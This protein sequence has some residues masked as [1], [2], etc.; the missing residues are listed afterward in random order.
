MEITQQKQQISKLIEDRLAELEFPREPSLLYDPVRYTLS[1]PGKRVRPYLTLIGCGLCGGG[2]IIKEA[3]PAAVSMELLHNFTL[4]HD[5]IMDGAETRRGAPSVYKKWNANTAILSG[6]AMYAKA[7]RRL[8]YYGKT[9]AFSK[10][11][12]AVILDLFLD[13]A[14]KVCEGQASDLAFETTTDVTIEQYLQM[15][16]GK[17]AALISGS[18]A[19]GGA[20]AGAGKDQLKELKITGTKAGIAFQIQDDL[21]DATAD[22]KKFGKKRGGDIIEG[23]KTYLT[24]LTLQRGNEQQKE[25]LLKAL[26]KDAV[27]EKEIVKV[28]N[29]Y[30]ELDILDDTQDAI[31]YYY[32]SAVEHLKNFEPSPFKEEII[33]FFN[34]LISREF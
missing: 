33:E 9:E 22:P 16:D 3:L 30:D 24:L 20:V 28:I 32:Q 2:D 18:L 4:L 25:I 5:D 31:N 34:N 23:K 27:T 11:E 29:I 10:R 13:S 21:L 14:E 7:F 17:T 8:Q 26:A 12:Y 1:L 19:M 15:I 6:D